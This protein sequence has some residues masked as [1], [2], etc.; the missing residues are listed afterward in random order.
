[1]VVK[2]D[3]AAKP[4]V[5]IQCFSAL[6]EEFFLHLPQAQINQ[7]AVVLAQDKDMQGCLPTI[8]R[9][10]AVSI[11]NFDQSLDSGQVAKEACGVQ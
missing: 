1:M 7:P 4:W 8:V 10:V 5:V 6:V 9:L 11:E 3:A 2:V